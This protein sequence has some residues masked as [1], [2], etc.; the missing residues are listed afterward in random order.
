M[1]KR[2]LVD[3]LLK[4]QHIIL[5]LEG[6]EEFLS[7]VNTYGLRGEK[8]KF[9]SIICERDPHKSHGLGDIDLFKVY[10]KSN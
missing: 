7:Y 2:I 6:I 5:N 4:E 1:K 10:L 8:E 9:A 3:K